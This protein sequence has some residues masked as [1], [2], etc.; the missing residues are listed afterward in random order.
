MSNS[1]DLVQ[2]VRFLDLTSLDDDDSTADILALCRRAQQPLPDHPGIRVAAVCTWA[3]FAPEAVSALAGT[4]ISVAVAAGGF[5]EPLQDWAARV[6]EIE[7]A[8]AAGANEIDAVI[9]KAEALAGNWQQ[10]Y[11]DVASIR[12]ICVNATLKMILATGELADS[13]II[14]KAANVCLQAGADFLK[15][16]TGREA[17][18]A[19]LP[20]GIVMARAIREHYAETGCRAGIKPAGGIRTVERALEWVALV[21]SELGEEWLSPEVF[22]IGASSLLDDIERGLDVSHE[23]SD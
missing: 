20:A 4:G 5:P 1:I 16:S 14:E 3:R 6:R 12:N 23:T 18:N 11:E 2:L 7:E 19:T 22:R 8:I 9:Q 21:R 17:V 13:Q 15:T 10:V